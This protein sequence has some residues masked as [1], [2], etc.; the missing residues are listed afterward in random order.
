[1][2][3]KSLSTKEIF[4]LCRSGEEY[5]KKIR[6]IF[7]KYLSNFLQDLSYFY[8]PRKIIVNKS[9]KKSADSFLPQAEK[10]FCSNTMEIFHF[11]KLLVSAVNKGLCLGVIS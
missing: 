5:V 9:L 10:L 8:N 4:E 6:D 1:L 7:V 11:E 3:R 2:S